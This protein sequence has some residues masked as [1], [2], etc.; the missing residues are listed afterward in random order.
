MMFIKY[1]S[2]LQF[3]ILCKPL[4]DGAKQFVDTCSENKAQS[5]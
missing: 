5:Y 4:P 2:A 1:E 3:T